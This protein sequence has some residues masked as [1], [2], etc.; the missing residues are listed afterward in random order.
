MNKKTM[1]AKKRI[2]VGPN[3]VRA[4]FDTVI[5][6]LLQA[7]EQEQEFLTRQNWSWRYLPQQ[8]E[9]FRHTQAY[10]DTWMRGN[11]EQ[12]FDFHQEIKSAA[13]EHDEA[14]DWL[15]D[16][17]RQL[18]DTLI[19]SAALQTIYQKT[20]TP[21][22][23]AELGVK[24]TDLFGGYPLENHLASLAQHIVNNLGELQSYYTTS[25][26][27]NRH[28]DEFL[29]VLKD[30]SIKPHYEATCQRGAALRLATSKLVELL[31]NC[32]LTLSLEYDVPYFEAREYNAIPALQ[33]F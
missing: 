29:A 15:A 28:R 5:N 19:Q 33:R 23:L 16:A 26:L 14:V 20:T 25:P 30:A 2:P 11:A 18:H 7:F 10:L 32:R 13:A 4:W 21:E 31:K 9:F 22:S 24:L 12:F 8:L 1:T 6:P 17:C 3:I 27:W